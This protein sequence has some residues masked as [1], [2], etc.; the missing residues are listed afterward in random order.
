[1][2]TCSIYLKPQWPDSNLPVCGSAFQP[3]FISHHDQSRFPHLNF[4]GQFMALVAI[5]SHPKLAMSIMRFP[6]L[7]LYKS[8]WPY[9]A[10]VSVSQPY[11][12]WFP[13]PGSLVLTPACQELYIQYSCLY[14]AQFL[15]IW[16]QLF[17]FAWNILSLI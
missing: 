17:L 6:S 8:L 15:L 7:V 2:T 5:C 13:C 3:S 10:W 4:S 16:F 14:S 1:M 9:L 11:L 12:I